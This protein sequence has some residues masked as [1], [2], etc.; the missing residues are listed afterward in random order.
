[1]WSKQTAA[2]SEPERALMQLQ[3]QEQPCCRWG[4]WRKKSV[5]VVL[6]Q[7]SEDW[8]AADLEEEVG[9]QLSGFKVLGG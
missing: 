7:D 8:R 9:T 1:M 4:P 3:C 2:Q 6:G 5:K